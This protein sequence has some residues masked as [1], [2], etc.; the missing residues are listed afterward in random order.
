M[1][2]WLVFK[3]A[4]TTVTDLYIIIIPVHVATCEYLIGYLI[5]LLIISYAMMY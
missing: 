2:E 5:I 4:R 1:A 3:N